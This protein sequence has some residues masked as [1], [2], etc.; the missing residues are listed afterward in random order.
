M[1]WTAADITTLKQAMLDRKGAKSLTFA[2]QTV[3]FDSVDDMMKL[4][5]VM[6]AEVSATAGLTRTRFA[7]TRKGL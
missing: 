1:A 5:A 3:V 4:L 7:A 6:E 2:D